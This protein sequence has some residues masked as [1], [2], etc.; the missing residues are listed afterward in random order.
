MVDHLII[1]VCH[2]QIQSYIWI[3]CN[4]N[5]LHD[6]IQIIF[7]LHIFHVSLIRGLKNLF[8]LIKINILCC[9]QLIHLIDCL[10]KNILITTFRC[11]QIRILIFR[12]FLFNIIFTRLHPCF[13]GIICF[14]QRSLNGWRFAL[15]DCVLY[16]LQFFFVLFQLFRRENIFLQIT[17]GIIHIFLGILQCRHIFRALRWNVS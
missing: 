1:A 13:I 10:L 3:F 9:Q 16:F 4:I 7:R 11:W 2:I 5:L 8:C 6:N 14:F 15:C 12:N 17:L